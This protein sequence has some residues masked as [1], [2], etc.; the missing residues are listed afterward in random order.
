MDTTSFGKSFIG[1]VLVGVIFLIK[2]VIILIV[3]IVVNILSLSALR[4]YINKKKKIG[5]TKTENRLSDMSVPSNEI[6]EAATAK[7]DSTKVRHSKMNKNLTYM[8]LVI[9]VFS[10]IG[11]FLTIA[12]SGA[13]MISQDMTSYGICFSSSL[14]ISFKHFFNIFIFLLFNNLFLSEFKSFL[15]FV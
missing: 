3:E 1:L 15:G 12:C 14:F 10:A 4:E 6:N 13:F 5:A 9:C 8:V 7:L 2:D 11:H